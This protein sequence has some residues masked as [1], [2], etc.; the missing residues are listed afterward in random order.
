M[1]ISKV[2]NTNDNDK[3][4]LL[5]Q[6]FQNSEFYNNNISLDT[7]FKDLVQL[8]INNDKCI[9]YNKNNPM[10]INPQSG[11][12]K[13]TATKTTKPAT[14]KTT[15][16]TRTITE[17]NITF[18]SDL[19]IILNNLIGLLGY[20]LSQSILTLSLYPTIIKRLI[21][22]ILTIDNYNELIELIT[23]IDNAYKICNIDP[24]NNDNN[25]NTFIYNNDNSINPI[26][27]KLQLRISNNNNISF[28]TDKQECYKS[29]L[30]NFENTSFGS[31]YIKYIDNLCI[32]LGKH[33]LVYDN[34]F[35][36]I[37]ELLFKET[38]G[39]LYEYDNIYPK[40]STN[41]NNNHEYIEIPYITLLNS[42]ASEDT[43]LYNI[44]GN[45]DKQII[46]LKQ[47]FKNI[48]KKTLMT[49]DDDDKHINIYIQDILYEH[50]AVVFL[51]M[52]IVFA[53]NIA[54][55]HSYT[56][57]IGKSVK[58]QFIELFNG[59]KLTT[60]TLITYTESQLMVLHYI[61]LTKTNLES[62]YDYNMNETNNNDDNNNVVKPKPI[63]ASRI[64]RTTKINNE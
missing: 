2:F 63:R 56:N 28:E 59:L 42:Y 52:L 64:R 20:E 6:G 22:E 21:D 17:K 53:K 9:T 13:K 23:I 25:D 15:K 18:G 36:K 62:I 41:D 4:I 5:L 55:F 57:S 1:D 60:P 37:W 10:K 24:N 11:L 26:I 33:K 31:V 54:I 58:L 45:I 19:K 32:E 30:S 61:L 48:T 35:M 44:I 7:L 8:F 12:L 46:Y 51:N 14:M 16:T 27:A 38:Y 34:Y 50:I 49:I 40:F 29:M 3:L 39:D 47:Y 43:S